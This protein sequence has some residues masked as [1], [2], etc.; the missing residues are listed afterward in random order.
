MCVCLLNIHNTT[1][2]NRECPLVKWITDRKPTASTLTLY[3]PMKFGLF[4]LGNELPDL[5]APF[6]NPSDSH[7]CKIDVGK[8]V[9]KLE[10]G[11]KEVLTPYLSTIRQIQRVYPNITQ[12]ICHC[13]DG[14]D[15]D[16][17]PSR[18]GRSQTILHG[19]AHAW[20]I[21][22]YVLFYSHCF[23]LNSLT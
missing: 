16:M 11:M 2:T 21:F 5:T 10:L 19:D 1:H 9:S 6:A 3:Y 12:Q 23:V 14:S 7:F 8:F 18:F 22:W 20:N 4:P 17:R 13:S 15:P